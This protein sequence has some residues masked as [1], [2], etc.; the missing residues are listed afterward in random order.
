LNNCSDVLGGVQ[1]IWKSL[2]FKKYSAHNGKLV[3]FNVLSPNM[4][5][6]TD[7]IVP[8]AAGFHYC[9]L[10]SPARALEWIYVDSLK[11]AK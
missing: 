10:I 8:L 2:E 7:Y 11:N 1:W 5:T 4:R 6:P 9:K 3:A